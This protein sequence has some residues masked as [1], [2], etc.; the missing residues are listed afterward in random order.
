MKAAIV[1]LAV[2]VYAVLV[3]PILAVFRVGAKEDEQ[4]GWK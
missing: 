1:L 3:A 4:M 2:F